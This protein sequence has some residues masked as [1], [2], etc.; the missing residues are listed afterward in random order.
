MRIVL[1]RKGV[2]SCAGGIPSPIMPDGTL[3][4]LPI[5]SRYGPKT[6]DELSVNGFQL[7][8]LVEDLA[9]TRRLKRKWFCHLDPDLDENSC[10]RPEGW[11]PA[12]GQ[13]EASQI[14]LANQGIGPGDLFLFFG[15]FRAV[16]QAAARWR[17]VR[18]APDHHIIYGWLAVGEAVELDTAENCPTQLTPFNDHAHLHM[19]DRSPNCLYL[20]AGKLSLPWLKCKG[21]GLFAKQHQ[22]RVLTD[23]SQSKRS[24]WKLPGWFHPDRKQTTLS[25]HEGGDRWQKSGSSCI[26]S[27]VARGQEFVMNTRNVAG[28]RDWTAAIFAD[29]AS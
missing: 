2:D 23:S 6:Y 22:A 27:S 8:P 13:I 10:A 24:V 9:G 12:F 28:L 18:G 29:V 19:W 4:P 16:E 7:G 1:S 21:A 25:C 20:S 26:L 17:F 3:V 5:P 11:R 14:H 15:W